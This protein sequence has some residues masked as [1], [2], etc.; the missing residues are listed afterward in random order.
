MPQKIATCCYCGTRAALVLS[1]SER[2]ELACQ[3]CGAPLHDL[4]RLPMARV[5]A[6]APE[7]VRPTSPG[8]NLK[9]K[10]KKKKRKGLAARVFEEAFDFLEDI[11]D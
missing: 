10:Q 3:S 2:H 1:G 4:K 9:K 5:Q 8:K 11:F 6:T 7:R